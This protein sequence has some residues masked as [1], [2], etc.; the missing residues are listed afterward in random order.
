MRQIRFLAAGV[1]GVT[2][3]TGCA[4]EG[5][6]HREASTAGPAALTDATVVKTNQKPINRRCPTMQE[7]RIDPH[8]VY[9]YKG[10]AIGFCCPDCAEGFRA[11]SETERDEV[12]EIARKLTE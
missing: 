11:M 6:A 5:S 3:L 12:L 7:H 4:T 1:V 10:V 2:V 8:E 9:L